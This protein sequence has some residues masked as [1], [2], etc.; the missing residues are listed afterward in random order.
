MGAAVRYISLLHLQKIK[1]SISKNNRISCLLLNR[2]NMSASDDQGSGFIKKR[3]VVKKVLAEQVPE[4]EGGIV[5]RSI[6]GFELRHFDPILILDEFSVSPPNGFPDHPHRGF[7]SVTYLLGGTFKH[8]DFTGHK[9]LIRAGDL[10]WI[11]AGRGIVHSEMPVKP[12][13]KG[14]Q[15]WVN[16]ASKDK[17]DLDTCEFGDSR[18]K[19]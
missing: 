2:G 11:T 17:I 7:E 19:T 4:G 16:L 3:L 1:T 18:A 10:R 9:G 5:G 14:L 15:L 6:G 8:E 13:S 12:H